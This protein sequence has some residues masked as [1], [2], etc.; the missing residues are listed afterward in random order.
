MSSTRT[1]PLPPLAAL[2]AVD[3]LGRTGSVRAAGDELHVS[4]TVISRHIQNLQDALGLQLVRP[5][6]RGIVLTDKGRAYHAEI[7]KAFQTLRAAR[8]VVTGGEARPVALWCT[9]GLV[10]R[11][12]LPR[13]STLDG[14]RS[15]LDLRI[16]PTLAVPDL[17]AG[18][19][20]AVVLYSLDEAPREDALSVESLTRPRVFPV[21]SPAFLDRFP[22]ATTLDGLAG[23]ALLH[24]ESTQ[25]WSAWLAAAGHAPTTALRGQHLWH[26]HLAIEAARLGQ[27]IAL[28]NEFLVGEELRAGALVEPVASDIRLG[29][30]R[31]LTARHRAGDPAL[32]ALRRWLMG[33]FAPIGALEAP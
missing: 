11:R 22:Q 1:R 8:D 31:L 20:D 24:E 32:K 30:Y 7:A 9:P 2:R 28:A 16:Q 6:G 5:S 3:A 27:G 21:A 23:A 33:A 25:Q 29:D 15:L 26:A 17:L 19:A 4:H 18:E 10:Y 13:L 14:E 12:L